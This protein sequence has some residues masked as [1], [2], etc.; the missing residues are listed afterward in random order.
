MAYKKS[1][2]RYEEILKAANELF[3]EKGFQNTSVQNIM[4]KIGVAKGGFYYYF[5]TK[6]SILDAL[7]DMNINKLAA[8]FLEIENR[9]DL[10]PLEKLKKMIIAEIK[11]NFENYDPNYHIHD[12]KNV[13]MHQKIMVALNRRIAPIIGSVICEG[14][15]K[16][17]FKTHYPLESSEI[18]LTGI[19]FVLDLGIYDLNSEKYIKRVKASAELIEKILSLKQGSFNFFLELLNDIPELLHLS[20][21]G[22]RQ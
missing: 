12:I 19:H 2:K 20:N 13:D 14:V 17:F 16:D 3:H 15:H 18:L 22:I 21:G 4:D 1:S 8:N 10:N 5:D 11:L 9:S 7:V 6:E